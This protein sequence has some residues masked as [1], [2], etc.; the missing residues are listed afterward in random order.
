MMFRFG[1]P[2]REHDHSEAALRVLEFGGI[3][4]ETATSCLSHVRREQRP[5]RR[6]KTGRLISLSQVRPMEC[7]S[8]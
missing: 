2:D 3:L 4:P 5:P 7:D 1:Q 6:Q 8:E